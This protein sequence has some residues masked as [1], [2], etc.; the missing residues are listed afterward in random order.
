MA[1]PVVRGCVAGCALGAGESAD[2]NVGTQ[3]SGSCHRDLRSLVCHE[4]EGNSW[5][6]AWRLRIH[7]RQVAPW[8][9]AHSRLRCSGGPAYL[10]AARYQSSGCTALNASW[11]IVAT[12]ILRASP[13]LLCRPHSDGERLDAERMAPNGVVDRDIPGDVDYGE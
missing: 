9:G 6:A 7:V 3:G 12:G 11:P 5:H 13:V 10:L 8:P 4:A 2:R 1:I